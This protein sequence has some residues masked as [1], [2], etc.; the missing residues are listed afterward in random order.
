MSLCNL[1]RLVTQIFN[2]IYFSGFKQ[3]QIAHGFNDITVK[4]VNPHTMIP[5]GAALS[6]EKS[7]HLDNL[8]TYD[9]SQGP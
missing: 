1:S 8:D 6:Y 7:G 5:N 3:L 4:T 9:W 2:G